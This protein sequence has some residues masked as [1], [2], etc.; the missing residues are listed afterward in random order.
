[1][2]HIQESSLIYE[3]KA[4]RVFSYENP[5]RV[6]IEFRLCPPKSP[7][8]GSAPDHAGPILRLRVLL[9]LNFRPRAE[10]LRIDIATLLA[11]CGLPAAF[12]F[13]KSGN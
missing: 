7:L 6:L 3:G 9:F 11:G 13:R 8:G 10:K 4:K 5:D 12:R 1:M 2:N